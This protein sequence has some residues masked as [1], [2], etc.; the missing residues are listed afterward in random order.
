M[1]LKGLNIWSQAQGPLAKPVQMARH[2]AGETCLVLEYTLWTDPA[3]EKW[4]DFGTC[5]SLQGSAVLFIG[6]LLFYGIYNPLV[7][8]LFAD[9]CLWMNCVATRSCVV[10][11]RFGCVRL[12]PEPAKG[13]IA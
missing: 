7:G 4:F 11:R 13:I 6:E 10:L 12:K 5:S 9:G 8:E 3:S 2:Q 1:A